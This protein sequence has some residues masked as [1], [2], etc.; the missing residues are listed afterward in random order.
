MTYQAHS[1]PLDFIFYTASQFPTEYRN[2]AFVTMRGSWNWN[3]SVGDKVVQLRH[4]NGKPV[5]FE[6]F[7]TGFL[8]A[9]G[10]TQ[11]GRP[12]GLATMPDGSL[13]W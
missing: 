9:N 11:F 4:Q 12:V 6:D 3:P 10:K 7:V 13:L 8:S 1:A 5:G 2:G